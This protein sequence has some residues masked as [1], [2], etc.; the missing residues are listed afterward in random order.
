VT[1]VK[2]VCRDVRQFLL[3]LAQD[4]P[5]IFPQPRP[6]Y[7]RRR[8]RVTRAPLAR[9]TREQAREIITA[10]VRHW[11]GALG[12]T[13]NRIAIK[14]H[15]TLW[16]SCSRRKNLNFNWRLAAAPAGTLDYIVIHELC[17]L[18]E[19]NHSKR[20]WEHVSRACPEFKARRRWLRENCAELYK[21]R[22]LAAVQPRLPAE[23]GENS[24]ANVLGYT[25]I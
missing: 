7:R 20:F 3:G 1:G 21:A 8:V 4:L 22:E 19:M 12:V 24:S 16:G 18:L 15:R 17:H 14:D 25:Q 2:G 13:Y 10:R 6:V 9:E 23:K 5:E 11:A